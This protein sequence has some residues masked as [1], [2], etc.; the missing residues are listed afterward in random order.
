MQH[1]PNDLPKPSE[2]HIWQIDLEQHESAIRR[3]GKLLSAAERARSELFHFDHLR[4]RYILTHGAL[5][6]I[7]AG[8][9]GRSA[10]TLQFNHGRFGKP[11]LAVPPDSIAFNLSHCEDL[12]LIAITAGR[13]V[14]IDVE[15]VRRLQYLDS[16]VDR[17][18]TAEERQFVTSVPA[19]EKPRAFFMVWTR[20]EAVAK[21][22]SLNLSA[23]L[24]NIDIPLFAKGEHALVKTPGGVPATDRGS[25]V[26][27]VVRDLEIDPHYCGAVCVEGK[28]C[29]LMIRE[30]K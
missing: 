16:I 12:A 7:L 22:L 19:H 3:F 4:Q 25:S 1:F 20:R 6:V 14:G 21:A 23:A 17:F 13:P 26:S 9:T 10:E 27:W 29:E 18:F 24:G 15:K 5:R 28:K 8:Y 2:I 30:F 11:F